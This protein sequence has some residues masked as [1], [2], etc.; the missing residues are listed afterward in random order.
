MN[1]CDR[2]S[3]LGDDVSA[4]GNVISMVRGAA[5]E[6]F[7]RKHRECPAGREFYSSAAKKSQATTHAIVR[8]A[9]R[10]RTHAIFRARCAS[11]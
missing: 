3:F 4:S 6:T 9:R 10:V 5:E 8:R 1:R 7:P 11:A 2:W